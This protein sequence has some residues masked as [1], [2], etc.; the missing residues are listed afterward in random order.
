MNCIVSGGTGFI[1]RHI[2]ARLRES[3]HTVFVWSR[4]AAPPFAWDPLQSEP[5]PESLEGVD[6]VIH[7][8]GETVAQRWNDDVK[9]RIADSRILGTRR[10]VDAISRMEPRPKVLVSASAVGYYGDR[11]GTVLTEASSPGKGFLVDVC[12]QW[13]AEADRAAEFGL[14][15]MKLRIGFVLGKD[16][17]ALASMLPPF[18]A[19]VGGRLGSGKQW[20]PWVHVVDVAH[21]FAYAMENQVSGVWNATAPNPVTNDEFTAEMSRILHRPAIFTV[22]PFAL[23]LAFGEMGQHMLDSARV[24]PDAPFKHAYVFHY[25][26]LDRALRNLLT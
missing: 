3:G 19:F 11:D 8:A 6:A 14:R 1:G 26:T 12:R 7:L 24:V 20:M 10:L 23:K 15:V 16:G 9:R 25:P 2:V 13:E 18:R 22:P 4:K 5:S 17:G 21:M